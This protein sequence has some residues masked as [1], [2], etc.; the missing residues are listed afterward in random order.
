MSEKT[1]DV[2]NDIENVARVVLTAA[3]AGLASVCFLFALFA[4]IGLLLK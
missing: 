1:E 3:G 4:F 2:L